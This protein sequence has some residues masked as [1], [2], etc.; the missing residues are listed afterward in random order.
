MRTLTFALAFSTTLSLG[1]AYAA[2]PWTGGD[3]LPTN[4]LAC[5]ATPAKAVAK[6][7]DGGTPTN[8]P[9]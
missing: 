2:S 5:D 6:P 7:Y 1:A 4:P 8:A 9:D 3:D